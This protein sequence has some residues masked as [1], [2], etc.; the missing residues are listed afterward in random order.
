MIINV[1]HY[2][3]DLYL[4]HVLGDKGLIAFGRSVSRDQA[5]VEPK[6]STLDVI[7][8]LLEKDVKKIIKYVDDIRVRN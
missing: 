1:E 8:T 6:K 2:L 3:S 4:S 5:F 7:K